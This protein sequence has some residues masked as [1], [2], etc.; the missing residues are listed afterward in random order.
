[1][2]PDRRLDEYAAR[3]YGAFCLAQARRAGFTNTMIHRRVD[4]AAW[5]RL[6]PGVY[7]LASAPPKWERQVAAAVLSRRTAIVSGFTAAHLHGLDGFPRGRPEITVPSGASARSR[8]ARVSRSIWFDELGTVRLAGFPAANVPETL[9]VLAGRIEPRRMER[10][11]DDRLAAGS[12]A[13]DDFEVIRRRVADGRVR[14]ARI[15]FPLLDERAIDAWVPPTNELEGFLARLVDHPDVPVAT[16]QYPFRFERL[17][18]IVDI[19]IAEWR[20]ILEADGRRWHSRRADFE[21]DR[22]RDNAAA[23]AGIA[24]LRFTWRMLTEDFEGCQRTLLQTGAA[25]ARTA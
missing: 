20:L 17:P 24:V 7:A 14:G 23:A 8:L 16:R 10:V 19:Y 11:L 9:L 25:R 21:R 6:A 4:S 22:A 2:S 3:Q 5:F 1:M 12:V 15:L 18:M 13:V